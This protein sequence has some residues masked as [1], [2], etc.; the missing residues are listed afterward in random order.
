MMTP[1]HESLVAI[2]Q[3][4]VGVKENW[5]SNSGDY[6]NLFQEE[7]DG[8]AQREPWCMGFVQFCLGENFRQNGYESGLFRSEHCLTVFNNS[9]H[10]Q[11]CEFPLYPGCIVIWQKNGTTQGH[12]GIIESVGE[13]GT[14]YT[15]EGNTSDGTGLNRDG[16][17]VYRRTRSLPGTG[18][19][20]V[21]GILDPYMA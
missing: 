3:L 16:D 7:V 21:V 6:V 12:T 20:T 18:N 10:L 14:L 17:G 9:K 8:V 19:F 2:A 1:A 15:I 4:Y 11:V 13:D 5:G